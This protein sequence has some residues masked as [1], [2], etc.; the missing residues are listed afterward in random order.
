MFN[1]I[2]ILIFILVFVYAIKLI[3]ST[4]DQNTS[5]Q[6]NWAIKYFVSSTLIVGILIFAFMVTR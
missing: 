2:L 3:T 4:S 5:K 6:M 1:A